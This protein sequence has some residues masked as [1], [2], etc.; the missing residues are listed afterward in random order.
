M[1]KNILNLDPDPEHKQSYEIQYESMYFPGGEYRIMLTDIPDK[2]ATIFHRMRS[3][4]DIIEIVMAAD[5]LR[6]GGV[7]VL[8]LSIPYVPYARQDRICNEGE[9]LSIKAF[10]HLINSVGFE[11]V[12]IFDPPPRS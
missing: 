4:K 1:K 7:K 3:P 9:S 12:S 5:A 10:A 2:E 6:R 8:N 11:K